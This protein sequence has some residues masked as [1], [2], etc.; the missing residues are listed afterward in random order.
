MKI[1][2]IF[3][4]RCGHEFKDKAL[5]CQTQKYTYA[6]T[7]Y[8]TAIGPN[9]MDLC[10]DCQKELHQWFQEKKRFEEKEDNG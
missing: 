4:D 2:S 9:F 5:V 10:D 8:M 1:T 7:R 6:V 3:C